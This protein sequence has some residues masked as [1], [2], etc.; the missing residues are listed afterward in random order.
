MRP[1]K[2]TGVLS[3]L[4]GDKDLK[5]HLRTLVGT[6]TNILFETKVKRYSYELK[7]HARALR[8]VWSSVCWIPKQTK[9]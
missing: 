8:L 1:Y 2:R 7:A 9:W 4:G 6:L 3:S 5:P